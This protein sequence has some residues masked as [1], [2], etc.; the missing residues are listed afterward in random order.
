MLFKNVNVKYQVTAEAS[1]SDQLQSMRFKEISQTTNANLVDHTRTSC[2]IKDA[3]IAHF[4]DIQRGK[5]HPNSVNY[6]NPN[7]HG[8]AIRS[9]LDQFEIRNLLSLDAPILGNL[10]ISLTNIVLYLSLSTYIILTLSFLTTNY[11]KIIA[12]N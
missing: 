4:N 11:N 5:F 3:V 8:K 9:P 1:N 10:H 2:C 7:A 6:I 12:H